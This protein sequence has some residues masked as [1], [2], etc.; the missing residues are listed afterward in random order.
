M[1]DLKREPVDLVLVHKLDR[2]ARDRYDAAVY[3]RIIKQRGARLV[4]V[5]QDY[6]DG[7]EAVILEALLQGMAEYYSL[8]LATEVIKGRKIRIR[9]GLYAGGPAPFGYR[10][11]GGRLVPDPVEA[12]YMALAYQSVLTGFPPRAQLLADMEAAGVRTRRGAVIDSHDLSRM[13][14]KPVYKGTYEASAGDEHVKIENNHPAIVSPEAWEEVRKI[15]D[16]RSAAGHRMHY[17]PYLLTPLAV[18]GECG[19]PLYGDTSY[20]KDADGNRK[21]RYRRYRCHAQGCK[22]PTIDAAYLDGLVCDYLRQLLSEDLRDQLVQT[23]REYIQDRTQAVRSRQPE[24]KREISKLRR[25]QDAIL[26]NMA[27]GILSPE[28]LAALDAQLQQIRKQIDVLDA[29]AHVPEDDLPAEAI[30]EYFADAAAVDPAED[31]AQAA[32]L[33]AR[34]IEKVVV[35]AKEIEIVPTFDKW[36]QARYPDLALPSATERKVGE[37]GNIGKTMWNSSTN[38]P[39]TFK[40]DRAFSSFSQRI[41]AFFK[42]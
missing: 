40:I 42:K 9:K 29:E 5:S 20:S 11:E 19:S 28:T 23:L 35:S 3:S 34:F 30:A 2:F 32:K 6:G 24:A 31:P 27:S 4:S 21:Y 22:N 26:Q 36:L 33:V 25:Q 14:R 41:R 37:D 16:K 38:A 18:C 12:H 17:T 15:M 7:P 10:N 8:N 39:L 13:M 1:S